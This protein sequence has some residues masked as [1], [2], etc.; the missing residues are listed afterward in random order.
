MPAFGRGSRCCES[1]QLVASAVRSR[2]LAR[3]ATPVAV[4]DA[5]MALLQIRTG[6]GKPGRTAELCTSEEVERPSVFGFFHPRI[7]IPPALLERL[8]GEELRQVVMHE[9]EHL[10][11]GDDWTN[12][13]QKIGAGDLSAESRAAVG[14]ARG[15]ARSASWPATTA[16]CA[17]RA[18]ASLMPFA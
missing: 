16:C 17:P 13:A 6:S 15:F 11:R 18:G 1:A 9:M 14:G 10:R 5:L 3:R 4:D 8:T 2:R 7:L 12:L